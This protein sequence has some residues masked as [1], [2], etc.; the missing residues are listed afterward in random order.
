[1]G[2]RRDLGRRVWTP[3]F[4]LLLCVGVAHA[5]DFNFS[6][7]ASFTAGKVFSGNGQNSTLGLVYHCPCFLANYEYAGV[8]DN[9]GWTAQ[10]ESL[11]AVQMNAHIDDDLSA[12]VQLDGRDVRDDAKATVDWAYLTYQ[13]N[14]HWSVQ[15][16]RKRIPMYYYAD[17]NYIGYSY[18]WVRPP[19]DVYGWDVYEYDGANV[20][21][22]T[23]FGD[24][25]LLAN[26]WVGEQDSKNNV[27]WTNLYNGGINTESNWKDIAGAYLDLS[28]DNYGFRLIYMQNALAVTEHPG[29]GG[30]TTPGMD[31]SWFR[32]RVFGAAFTA[33]VNDWLVRAEVNEVKR[34]A[35]WAAPAA[36]AGI[37]ALGHRFGK[38]TVMGTYSVYWENTSPTYQYPQRDYTRTA[39]V[40]WDFHKSA[41]LKFQYDSV[42]DKSPNGTGGYGNTF[43]DANLV[44]V[45]LVTV[46]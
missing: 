35:P 21:Y 16:G 26:G 44:T 40:R 24:W 34:T 25:G 9:K 27:Y 7:F 12:T 11:V 23:N 15:A 18:V 13:L 33:D 3:C 31:G 38:F 19:V 45:S 36:P 37:V 5:T 20:L 17:S 14:N 6:G 2:K 39:T 46:F 43:G 29:P 1:M 4:V 41:A 42:K 10:P 22:R 28:N 32:Q 30:A 8:Y